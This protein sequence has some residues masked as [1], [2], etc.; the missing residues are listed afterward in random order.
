MGKLPELSV[1]IPYKTLQELLDAAASVA[2]L[3]QTIELR[4]QQILAMRKQLSEVFEVIGEI[5]RELR[6][7]HD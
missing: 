2:D 7:Y 6:S 5:K 4:D 3:K 1:V